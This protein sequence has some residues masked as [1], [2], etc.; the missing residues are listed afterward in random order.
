LAGHAASQQVFEIMGRKD[1][2]TPEQILLRTRYAEGLAAYRARNWDEASTAFDAALKAVPG[3]G[4][5]MTLAARVNSFRSNPPAD[6][7][8]GAWRLDHK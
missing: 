2:L 4:P 5:A 7:W 8:D 1:E 6:D 3:D